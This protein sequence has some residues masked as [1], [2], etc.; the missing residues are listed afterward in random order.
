MHPSAPLHATWI[1]IILLPRINNKFYNND[2]L[3]NANNLVTYFLFSSP[4]LVSPSYMVHT[5]YQP[6]KRGCDTRKA[7]GTECPVLMFPLNTV[8]LPSFSQRLG[9]YTLGGQHENMSFST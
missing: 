6:H 3:N 2:N 4:F 5:L 1:P 8:T 7:K 9:I